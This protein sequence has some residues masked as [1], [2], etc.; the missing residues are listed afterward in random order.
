M[1]AAKPGSWTRWVLSLLG[2]TFF[3]VSG[4][5][6]Y[7]AEGASYLQDD[8]LA[9]AN[10]HVMQDHYDGWLKSSH[11]H[12]ASCNDCHLPHTSFLAKWAVKAENGYWHS[13]KFTFQNFEEPIR[14]RPYNAAVLQAN[15]IR[16]HEGMVHEILPHPTQTLAPESCVQCHRGVGHGPTL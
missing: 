15:C 6:F 7:F 16:C 4:Y 3:G 13:Y 9:C 2:G 5:A 8:P 1:K 11:A 10:C 12:V 14:I